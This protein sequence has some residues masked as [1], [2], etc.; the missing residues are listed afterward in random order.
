MNY[1]WL[2]ESKVVS[3]KLNICDATEVRELNLCD[4]LQMR[5]KNKS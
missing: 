1:G 2:H 3:S 5:P 4:K